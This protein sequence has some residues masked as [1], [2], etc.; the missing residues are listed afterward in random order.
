MDLDNNE[1]EQLD[2]PIAIRKGYRECRNHPRY[3]MSKYV[4]YEGLSPSF[5]SFVA[6]ISAIQIP[7][8]IH[9]ALKVPKWRAAVR[10]EVQ[11]LEKNGTWE[12]TELPKG[13]KPVGCKWIFTVKH[14][15]DGSIER[16]KARLVAKGLTLNPMVLTIKKHLL[17]L[18]S[19]IQ[20]GS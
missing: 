18:L 2:G 8:N 17:R 14:K 3:P 13:K 16:F 15:A 4:S 6:N 9:D 5:R 7:S 10:E 19:L 1:K 11:A 20:F 12:I